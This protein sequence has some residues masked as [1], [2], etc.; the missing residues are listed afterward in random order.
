MR[1]A[2]TDSSHSRGMPVMLADSA[3]TRADVGGALIGCTNPLQ[4]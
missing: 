3:I 4:R 1:I 2:R